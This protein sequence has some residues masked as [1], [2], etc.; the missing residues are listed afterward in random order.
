MG[1]QEARGKRQEARGKRQE[2]R[3]KRGKKGT[4]N[5]GT[6]ITHPWPLPGGEEKT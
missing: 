5:T 1:E 4:G 2:A 6:G 3:G